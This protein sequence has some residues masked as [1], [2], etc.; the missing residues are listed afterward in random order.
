MTGLK[1]TK[2][3]FD[4]DGNVVVQD[5]SDSTI[6]I[7][8]NNPDEVV[9]FLNRISEK[10][11]E[12]PSEIAKALNKAKPIPQNQYQDKEELK[13]AIREILNE[14]N[15]IFESYGPHSEF[16]M[17][18]TQSNAVD[19][20]RDKTVKIIIPNNQKLLTIL[21]ENTNLLS[22]D[23]KLILYKFKLHKEG[24]EQNQLSSD[25]NSTVPTF[26]VELNTIF[27]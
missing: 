19:I 20:W 7:N 13:E 6:T 25:K 17:N 9:D 1:I 2:A 14:N 23:E 5:I 12:L 8:L 11:N 21:E 27:Q 26:P 18:E 15:Y 3:E 24:F 10:I 4:G 16:A 22:A